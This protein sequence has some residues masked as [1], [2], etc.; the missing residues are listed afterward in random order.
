[1]NTPNSEIN[2]VNKDIGGL[3]TNHNNLNN[4]NEDN[5]NNK[6][7]DIFKKLNDKKSS[8]IMNSLFKY[9][10]EEIPEMLKQKYLDNMEKISYNIH[11]FI[12]K[13]THSFAK[14]WNIQFANDKNAF[15]EISDS[16]ESL[17]CKS[18]YNIIMTLERNEQCERNDRLLN[19]FSFL[20]LKHLDINFEID[21]FELSNKLK[22]N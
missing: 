10:N 15:R 5:N 19:K 20:T 6:E 21:E 1:M 9:L 4:Q 18:L 7:N 13:K 16:Y 2:K 14:I 17:I 12:L 22:G 8:E 11:D 3:L